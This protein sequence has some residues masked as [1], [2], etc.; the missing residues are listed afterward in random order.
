[1]PRGRKPRSDRALTGAERQAL[2]QTSYGSG[3][4]VGGAT[5]TLS[6]RLIPTRPP[7]AAGHSVGEPRSPSSS[8]SRRTT[9]PSSR[10]GL[11]RD[12]LNAI[13]PPWMRSRLTT[14]RPNRPSPDARRDRVMVRLYQGYERSFDRKTNI[15]S[16]RSGSPVPNSTTSTPGS[17]PCIKGAVIGAPVKWKH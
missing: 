13:D 5:A 15:A 8:R 7:T 9:R 11:D 1:M 2:Y 6:C 12:E 3:P 10:H 4:R 14:G 16:L 17:N